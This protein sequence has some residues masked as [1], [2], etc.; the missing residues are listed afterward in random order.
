[1]LRSDT[2][3]EDEAIVIRVCHDEGADEAGG[4]SPR[5]RVDVLGVVVTVDEGDV[6]GFGKVLAEVVGGAGLDGFFILNHGLDGEGGFGTGEAFGFGFLSHDDGDGEEVADGIRV[7]LMDHVGFLEGLFLGL[8]RGVAFLPEELGGA[9]EEAGAHFPAHDVCPLVDEKGEVAVG[10]GPAREGGSDDGLGGGTNDV[11]LGE[12][13]AGDHFGFSG[14]GVFF[15]FE[16]VVGD[17]GALGGKAL[18]VLGFFFEIGEGD[19]E[20]EVGVFMAGGLEA[21]IEVA[22]DGFPDGKAPR[23]DDHASS[24]FGIFSKVGGSDD[25]LIP[26]GKVLGAGG[27]DCRFGLRHDGRRIRQAGALAKKNRDV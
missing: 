10:L 17:D 23:L 25:L 11:G 15:C 5:G 21:A 4:D 20:G 6:L 26:L 13:A 27:S 24:G 2:G 18:G 14:D 3:R 19:E 12:F 16:T 8:V 22:L 9:E 1:M 7:K